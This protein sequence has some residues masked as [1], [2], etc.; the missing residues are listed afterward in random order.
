MQRK[1]LASI[2]VV[3]VLCVAILF[4]IYTNFFLAKQGV[5]DQENTDIEI[6]VE[7]EFHYRDFLEENEHFAN[8]ERLFKG[9]KY[10]DAEIEYIEGLKTTENLKEEGQVKYKLAQTLVKLDK[11]AEGVALYK[12]IVAHEG[13]TDIIRAYSVQQLGALLYQYNS[14]EVRDMVFAGEPYQNFV[15]EN[16]WAQ[17]RMKLFDYGSSFY[18]LGV[19]ELRVAQWYSEQIVILS[20]EE[21]PAT[22]TRAEIERMKLHVRQ[23]LGNADQYLEKVVEDDQAKNYMPEVMRRKASVLGDMF[24]AGDTSFPDPIPV[25]KE[26]LV[27]SSLNVFQEATTK[28]NYATFLAGA[29]GSDKKDEVISLLKGFYENDRY[30]HTSVVQMI[31]NEE[32]NLLGYRD[33]ILLLAEIDPLFREYLRSL[34]WDI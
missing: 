12:E 25:Y 1:V 8:A 10:A 30:A 13:Y 33:R 21:S 19:L 27:F 7:P 26:A 18:P 22:S 11:I 28:Y 34:G 20:Q 3:V 14:E 29:Y 6:T 24:I 17:S 32:D 23:R 9:G 15:V 31:R 4:L 16:D 2:I 5:S